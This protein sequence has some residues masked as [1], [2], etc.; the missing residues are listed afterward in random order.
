MKNSCQLKDRWL[1][2]KEAAKML[3]T[4]PGNL[5]RS[6]CDGWLYKG[7]ET[8]PFIKTGVRKVVYSENDLNEYMK[9]VPRFRSNADYYSSTR[10]PLSDISRTPIKSESNK[11]KDKEKE[12]DSNEV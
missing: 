7:V 1:D 11:D 10:T 6:R 8:P 12:G 9:R 3:G 2:E 5:R 4:T